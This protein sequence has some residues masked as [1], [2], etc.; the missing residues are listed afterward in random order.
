MIAKGVLVVKFICLIPAIAIELA[1]EFGALPVIGIGHSCGA[2]LQVLITSLFPDAPRALNVLISFNNRQA[3]AAIPAYEE[4][5][6]PLSMQLNAENIQASNFRSV[7]SNLRS[8][9]GSTANAFAS[10]AVVPAFVGR[11]ILPLLTQSFE[12]VCQK[13]VQKSCI[14]HQFRL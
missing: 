2:L 10:S 11:E 9:I 6:I 12:M 13:I 4:I 7:L 5:I 14:A 8:T 3:A 1:K